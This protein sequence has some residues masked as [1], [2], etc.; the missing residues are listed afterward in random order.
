M[1]DEP[2][3]DFED[4]PWRSDRRSVYEW[5]AERA[6]LHDE[7]RWDPKPVAYRYVGM[8]VEPPDGPGVY[9]L[10]A[11]DLRMLYIGKATQISRRLQGHFRKGAVPFTKVWW[12]EAPL[13][14]AEVLEAH[15]LSPGLPPYNSKFDPGQRS[16]SAKL[17]ALIERRQP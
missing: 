2:Y 14:A 4:E 7:S 5:L 15:L 13:R 17:K 9:F 1:D 8:D 11:D 10:L 3:I 12:L 16:D 6:D